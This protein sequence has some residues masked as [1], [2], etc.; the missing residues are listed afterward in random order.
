MSKQASDKSTK[1]SKE[2]PEHVSAAPAPAAPAPKQRVPLRGKQDLWQLPAL[3]IGGALL[4]LGV[5]T[6]IKGAPRPDFDGALNG[7]EAMIARQEYLPALDLLNGPVVAELSQPEATEEVK[8]RF[9]ALRADAI[10]LSQKEAGSSVAPEQA[11]ANNRNVL[12][13]YERAAKYDPAQLD[14]RR[15][16]FIAETLL[17]LGKFDDALARIRSLPDS[18]AQ[19]RRRLL[20]RTITQLM[21][22]PE[23]QIAS[24]AEA[25]TAA[26]RRERHDLIGELLLE[27]RA[28]PTLE[29]EDRLWVTARR[30]ER[31]LGAGFP[32]EAIEEV[33]PEIQRLSN[34]DTPVV[35][36]L[37]L[38]L[39]RAYLELGR[40]EQAQ[41]NLGRAEGLLPAGDSR[42]GEVEVLLARIAQVTNEL[43]EARDRYA[44]AADRFVG[45]PAELQAYV[46]L[47]EVEADLNNFPNSLKA[48]AQAIELLPAMHGVI[49]ATPADVDLSLTQ[50]YQA[51]ALAGDLETALSY[52]KLCVEAYP[53]DAAPA[54]ATLRLAD[55][56]L[57]LAESVLH[58]NTG[59]S[60]SV[61]IRTLDPVSLDMVRV[62]FREAGRAYQKHVQQSTVGD[63]E[64]AA[65]S[66]WKAADS[67]DRA[68]DQEAAIGLFTE[69]MQSRRQ[70]P[71]Q[72][73]ARFR[74][75]RAFAAL[76]EHGTAIRLFEQIIAER[77]G[78]DEAYR[79]YVPL[80]QSLIA[81]GG[82]HFEKAEQWLLQVVSGRIFQPSAPQFRDAVVEL[83][84]L[85][86]R[87]SRF[88]DA[89][90]RL[91]E[92]LDRYPD[93][94]D[95][96]RVQ[97]E[98]ADAH[99]LSAAQMDQQLKDA[100][101]LSER[102]RVEELRVAR[103]NEALALYET[104]RAAL[105]G[106]GKPS[107]RPIDAV[108]LRNAIFY[109][110]DCAFDL[111][112]YDTAIRYYDAAAQRYSHDPAS[113]VAMVQ[114]VN[115]YASLGKWREAS[116]AHERAQDRLR[117]M[118]EE[119]W[120]T[121]AVPMD[122]RHWERWLEASLQIREQDSRADADG[123]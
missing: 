70:D 115:C 26:S 15:Q 39:G 34:T 88:P 97:F 81:E 6:F 74:L 117:E 16:A 23:G 99:R 40:I 80:A 76:G 29:E 77:P 93:L 35:G 43:E 54:E 41:T 112:Q 57:A 87:T 22:R 78:S 8:A 45:S 42:R 53:S 60:G 96:T 79:S 120:R 31:R 72:Y 47:G 17:D 109:R 36:E 83:G 24:E 25:P 9:H 94:E 13:E 113:L 104:V 28:D 3:A 98:L 118:P 116:T 52:A 50:R 68:G 105:E 84:R 11:L 110:G 18:D 89:I 102:T 106:H 37:F 121:G 2:G 10:Y 90:E 71:R 48:Y 107:A 75:A 82:D 123:R 46:G 19:R 27:L 49:G 56:H 122:R 92:A 66:L 32:A 44:T 108:M 86:L 4:T 64:L 58:A 114:I 63:P 61:D 111:G 101:P 12:A 30:A 21:G 5:M 103:L 91:S 119:A 20:R 85:Y 95:R 1:P 51:R 33:I 7:A 69:F 65:A 100:M 67:F 62:H 14:T 38:L 59:E 73:E 55:A